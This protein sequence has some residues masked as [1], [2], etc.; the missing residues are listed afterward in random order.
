LW[1]RNWLS[2]VDIPCSGPIDIFC[3]NLG[4]VS[5]TETSKNHHIAKHIDIR[6]HF[7]RD[8]VENGDLHVRHVSSSGNLADFLTKSLP[9]ASHSRF[10]SMLGLDWKRLDARG[11]VKE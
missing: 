7:V 1:M 5:L 4:T 6:F 9:K 11:S 2:E 3:D 10:V 8:T